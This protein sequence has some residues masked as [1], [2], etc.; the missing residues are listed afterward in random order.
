LKGWLLLQQD[1]ARDESQ[2]AFLSYA[3]TRSNA[4]EDPKKMNSPKPTSPDGQPI[5]MDWWNRATEIGAIAL[6]SSAPKLRVVSRGVDALSEIKGQEELNTNPI[7]LYRRMIQVARAES[8]A[9]LARVER[10]A[11]LA[12]ADRLLNWRGAALAAQL[13]GLNRRSAGAG[14]TGCSTGVGCTGGAG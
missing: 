1:L 3:R 14:C 7:Y 10:L 11:R 8:A 4:S 5:G 12:R 13:G 9:Q 2:K 6:G